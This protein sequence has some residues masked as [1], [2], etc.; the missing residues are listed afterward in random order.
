MDEDLR[1]MGMGNRRSVGS[2]LITDLEA[3]RARRMEETKSTELCSGRRIVKK[4]RQLGK[5][6]LW[7]WKTETPKQ[8]QKYK[9]IL[10]NTFFTKINK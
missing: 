3:S 10:K 2:V 1:M 9:L 8:K 6:K 7:I 4:R 5:A